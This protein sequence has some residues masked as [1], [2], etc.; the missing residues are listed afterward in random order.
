MP[1]YRFKQV[2]AF[3]SRAFFG[4]PVA[5]VAGA[6]GL[7]AE[8][9]Q[10][11]AAWTNLSE[12]TFVLKPTVAQPAYRLRIFSPGRELPFAGH[13]TI[14]SCH[15]VLEARIVAPEGGRLVQECGAGNLP[16]RVDGDGPGRWIYVETPQATFVADLAEL[17]GIVS[18]ALG[19]PIASSPAPTALRN[20]PTW[21]FVRFED[22]TDVAALEPD[23]SLVAKLSREHSLTGVAA[24]AFVERGEFAIHIR[25]FAPSVGV[26]EDPV[27]GS[28]NAALPAYLARHGLLGRTGREYLSTQGTELGRDGR[29]HVRVM[30]ANGRAE[31]GGQVVTV[32]EGEIAV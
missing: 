23:M 15:A 3:T 13:P 29:V 6:D 10:R 25:C 28:A 26:P 30:D 12:T 27:T 32:V 24:F 4:N 14:G 16:L 17:R 11:I 21:L 20:G 2:D 1:T 18:T 31:I 5:V 8:E 9:M 7:E 19:R 22:T